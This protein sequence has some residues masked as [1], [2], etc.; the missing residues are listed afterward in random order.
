MTNKKLP[1]HS[2]WLIPDNGRWIEVG[3]GW[4]NR[5]GSV[6]VTFTKDV[7]KGARLQLRQ[8]R[9]S[10][11]AMATARVALIED[12]KRRQ[13]APAVPA[14]AAGR[15]TNPLTEPTSDDR[16][17]EFAS[18]HGDAPSVDAPCGGVFVL[19]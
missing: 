14:P 13:A 6:N 19:G 9:H 5:D 12:E 2:I 3:A 17:S 10:A 16:P 18:T 7:A 8:R 1:S 4:T 15:M 11:E